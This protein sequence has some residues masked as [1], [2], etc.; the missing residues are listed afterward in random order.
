MGGKKM[1]KVLKRVLMFVLVIS[2]LVPSVPMVA[3]ANAG[4]FAGGSGTADDPYIIMTAEQLD[5]V[6]H[7]LNSH[8]MLG[9]DIDLSLYSSGQGWMPIGS[10]YNGF[11]G[12]FD[13]DGYTISNL[14]IDRSANHQGLFG[15][16]GNRNLSDGGD[17]NNLILKDV[18]IKQTNIGGSLAG[19]LYNSDVSNVRVESGNVSGTGSIGG[20]IGLSQSSRTKFSYSNAN[21]TGTGDSIGGLIGILY[22]YSDKQPPSVIDQSFAT[23]NVKT[24]YAFAGGLAG[25]V[26][27]AKVINSYATGEVSAEGTG[28]NGLYYL[29]G[30]AGIITPEYGG[31]VDIINSHAVGVVENKPKTAGLFGDRWWGTSTNLLDS[32]WNVETTGQDTNILIPGNGRTTAQMAAKDTFVNWDFDNVWTYEEGKNYPVLRGFTN[33]SRIQSTP[34]QLIILGAHGNPGDIDPYTEY[35]L[36]NGGTWK[37]AYLFGWHPWGFVPGTNSWINCKP[38]GFECLN[39]EVLYRVRFNVPEGFTNPE[40]K[41]D[42]KADN[43]AKIWLN[44][45]YVTRI[46]GGGGTTADATITSALS[47]G[48][49]EIKLLVQDWGGWAG[50]NYKITLNM[51]APSAPTVE[52]SESASDI[53]PPV[54]TVDVPEAPASG[55]Y[56]RDVTLNFAVSE[57]ATTEYRINGGEWVTFTEAVVITEGIY[58][59]EYRS[60]DSN[61]NVEDAKSM[62]L[63]IDYTAPTTTPEFTSERNENGWYTEDVEITLNG[64]DNVTE[65]EKIEYRI[66]GE[67]WIVYT[68]P[69]TLTEGTNSFEYRSYDAAGNVE[70]V[71]SMDF[72]IDMTAPVTEAIVAQTANDKGWYTE[73]VTLELSSDDNLSGSSLTE[74]RINGGEWMTY[75]ELVAFTDGVWEVEYRSYDLAGNEEGIQTITFHIDT[76]APELEVTLNQYELWSPNHKMHDII[77]TLTYEDVTSQIANVELVSITSNE[78]DSVNKGDKEND[79]QD[80]EFGTDDA[81]FKLRAERLGKGEGRVYTITYKVTDAAGHET[82][83]MVEVIV[84]HDKGNN[85]N[86][87]KKKTKK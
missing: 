62:F 69:F 20:L 61:G 82:T 87:A 22:A 40:L 9:T 17:I 73:E 31:T 13:G 32:Y 85:K 36:D 42:V 71:R 48:I 63:N 12:S 56:D 46:V 65:A 33:E 30:L 11:V 35:S 29:G 37:P 79:I 39:Q 49:N 14:T 10:E 45:T 44:G 21:V 81:V 86:E 55:W 1:N 7:Y 68:G 51:E 52:P 64:T 23:G 8:F 15:A 54:T 74:Y 16:V 24:G 60:V 5:Q 50:F 72:H 66:N 53:E 84:P 2:L 70:D 41:F 58:E 4:T 27:N 6:R 38:S 34:Q 19:I 75:K 78:P 25:W 26:R 80:A 47:P 3:S 43:A 77:A 76:V 28:Y 57:D 83:Q 18:S 67:E 59:V